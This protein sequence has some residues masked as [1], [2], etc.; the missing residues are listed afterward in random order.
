MSAQQTEQRSLFATAWFYTA[1]YLC[2][3][4]TAVL[5]Y[6]TF[7]WLRHGAWLPF[8]MWNVLEWIGWQNPPL[9]TWTGLQPL[10]DLVW[11][12]IGNCP[13]TI[14]GSTAAVMAAILGFASEQSSLHNAPLRDAH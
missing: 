2:L 13:I 9:L 3:S 4:A 12:L 8:Q 14:A 1:G 5:S 10:I 11:E 7:L 6:Q